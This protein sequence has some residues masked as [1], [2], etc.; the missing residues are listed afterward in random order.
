M[1]QVDP[2]KLSRSAAELMEFIEVGGECADRTEEHRRTSAKRQHARPKGRIPQPI[3]HQEQPA[4]FDVMRTGTELSVV[5]VEEPVDGRDGPHHVDPALGL[6]STKAPAAQIPNQTA[7][8]NKCRD[9]PSDGGNVYRER[10][11]E[12]EATAATEGSTDTQK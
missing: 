2:S 5:E 7:A 10:H 1:E 9:W 3:Q 12:D 4:E 8:N 6:L 11:G